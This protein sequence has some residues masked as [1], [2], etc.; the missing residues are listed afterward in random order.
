MNE[1]YMIFIVRALLN[2]QI[3]SMESTG[4]SMMSVLC[5]ISLV[6]SILIPVILIIK[7]NTNFDELASKKVIEKYG[8]LYKDI[9]LDAGKK[10]LFVPAF[11]LVRRFMLGIVVCFVSDS[12]ALQSTI[13]YT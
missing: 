3:L 5:A 7:L 10:V 8:A 11:F 13:M 6:L 1:S 4:L 2:I 9:K 12:I